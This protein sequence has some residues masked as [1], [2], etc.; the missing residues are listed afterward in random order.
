MSRML[1]VA[2][3]VTL[4]LSALALSACAS[5]P[6]AVPVVEPAPTPVAAAEKPSAQEATAEPAAAPVAIAEQPAASAEPAPKPVIRKARK[7]A[8][9]HAP[10]KTQPPPSDIVPAPIVEQQAPAI[11]P[12]EPSPPVTIAPPA[13]KMAEASFL[14]RYW[15]WLLGLAV[16]IAVAFAWFWRSQEDKH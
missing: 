6:E 14:E 8:A 12:P 2:I 16:V 11:L 5:K 4:L 1:D 15:Q 9:K 7:I 3:N 10:P 13:E